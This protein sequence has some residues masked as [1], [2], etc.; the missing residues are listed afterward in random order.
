MHYRGGT[1]VTEKGGGGEVSYIVAD[2]TNFA[3]RVTSNAFRGFKRDGWFFT[4]ANFAAG[5]DEGAR[6]LAAFSY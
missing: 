6:C 4:K 5:A 2:Q 3:L 1:A